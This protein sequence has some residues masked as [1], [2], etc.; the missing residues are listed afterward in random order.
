[1]AGRAGFTKE[2]GVGIDMRGCKLTVMTAD[3]G[4]R[5]G[6][7]WRPQVPGRIGCEH[8][9]RQRQGEGV[10]DMA[11]CTIAQIARE[12]DFAEIMQAATEAVYHVGVLQLLSTMDPVDHVLEVDGFRGPGAHRSPGYI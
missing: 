4:R 6:L 7:R 11:F 12:K 9:F 10:V 1:M 2:A 3:A 8:A 5:D